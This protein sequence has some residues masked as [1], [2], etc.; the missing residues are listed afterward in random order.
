[1]RLQDECRYTKHIYIGSQRVVSKIGDFDYYGSDPRRIQYA[2]GETDGLSVVAQNSSTSLD[3][4]TRQL[5]LQD[6]R[7][8]RMYRHEPSVRQPCHSV[9]L[10]HHLPR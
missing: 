10:T 1:M 6:G 2:G 5:R 9:E 8:H 4:I 7:V 3:E